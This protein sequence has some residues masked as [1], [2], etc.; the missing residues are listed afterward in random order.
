MKFK[1]SWAVDGLTL[2]IFGDLVN[3][4]CFDDFALHIVVDIII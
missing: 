2:E 3:D 4:L 1:L